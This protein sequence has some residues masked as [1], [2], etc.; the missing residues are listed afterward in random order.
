MEKLNQN[1]GKEFK[2]TEFK[3]CLKIS[4]KYITNEAIASNLDE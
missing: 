4:N 3:K 2:D 1:E